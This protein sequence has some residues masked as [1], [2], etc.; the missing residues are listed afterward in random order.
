MNSRR[1]EFKVVKRVP[2]DCYSRVVGFYTPVRL[3]NKGKKAEWAERKTYLVEGR[4]VE[5]G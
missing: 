1:E 3:W 2:V 4:V 5:E